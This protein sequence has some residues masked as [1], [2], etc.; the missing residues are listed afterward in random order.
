MNPFFRQSDKSRSSQAGQTLVETMVAVFILV[1]GISAA[2]G[3]ANYSLSSTT[4]I[5]KQII[6]MGL[7]REGI[8]AVKNMRD[9]NWLK[10]DIYDF[11]WNFYDND[12]TAPCYPDWLRSEQGGFNID[13]DTTQSYALWFDTTELDGGPYWHFEPQEAKG[14]AYGLDYEGAARDNQFGL[15]SAH[16]LPSVAN[17]TSDYA[18][19]IT[20][21]VEGDQAPFNHDS[22]LG[23]RLKVTSQVWWKDKKCP[24]S[25][26]VPVDRRC[27]ITLETYLTNWKN[28]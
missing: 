23:P 20:L 13:P 12:Y 25:E 4:N 17:A 27:T 21:T 16:N 18:R 7:A 26:D 10:G 2:L 22:D 3:L 8:E 24:A 15:Y 11:C 5:R 28:Y 19:K 6:A 14:G 9:T 1:M